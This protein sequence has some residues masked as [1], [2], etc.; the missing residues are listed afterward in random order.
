MTQEY[1]DDYFEWEERDE[2]VPFEKHMIA[3]SIAGIMEHVSMLPVDSMKTHMQSSMHRMTIPESI[4]HIRANG[5]MSSF[6]RG[7]SI[8]AAG[9]IPAHS[10]YFSIYEYSRE[11]LGLNDSEEVSFSRNALIGVFSTAFHDMIM[12]PCEGKYIGSF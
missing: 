3:G 12:N 1:K 9:C 8:M 2:R 6:W 10:L 11:N 4:T 7:T 5:G